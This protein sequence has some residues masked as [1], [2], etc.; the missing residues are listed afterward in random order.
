MGDERSVN[1]V[2]GVRDGRFRGTLRAHFSQITSH[3]TKEASN[4]TQN[5]E[6]EKEEPQ[7]EEGAR[8]HR[9]WERRRVSDARIPYPSRSRARIP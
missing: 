8:Q 2:K 3:L 7:G 5:D 6:G 1:S 4:G 9:D